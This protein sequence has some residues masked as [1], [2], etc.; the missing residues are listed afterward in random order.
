MLNHDPSLRPTAH[1]ILYTLRIHYYS[2]IVP[3]NIKLL[4]NNMNEENFINSQKDLDYNKCS[5][6]ELIN[7][8]HERDLIIADQQK[9][10]YDLEKK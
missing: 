8:L 9:R 6:E 2:F 10:I 3:N 1:D 7:L 5:K 4:G